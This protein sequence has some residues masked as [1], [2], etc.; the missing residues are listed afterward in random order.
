MSDGTYQESISVTTADLTLRS[1][2][3]RDST[4]IENAGDVVSPE[5]AQCGFLIRGPAT[6]FTL[7]GAADQGFT[8][9]GGTSTRLIQLNNGPSGVEISYNKI[10]TTG[11]ATTG[12][13]IGAAGA[14]GLTVSNNIF[15][16]DEATYQD[17]PL[18][19]PDTTN[20]VLDVTVTG[21][22]FTGS[23]TPDK[24][25]AAICLGKIGVSSLPESTIAG[26]TI[27][28]FD[29]GIIISAD[30]AD[31]DVSGN[32]IS[33]CDK[34]VQ[35]RTGTHA[36]MENNTFANNTYNIYHAAE[37]L[38]GGSSFY[39]NIQDAIDAASSGD[40]I[41]VY[42]GTYT[43]DLV[44]NIADLTL[45][46]ETGKANTTIQ[47]VDG[48]GIDIQGGA[49]NFTLG[50]AVDQGFTVLSGTTTTFLIQLTNAPSDVEI[51]YNEI[52]T[53]GNASQ[54]ISVGAAGATFDHYLE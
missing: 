24:Y 3:G 19:G 21:N 34:G 8:F 6:N 2:N 38:T 33:D 37:I 36:E 49:S 28:A 47:L 4:I 39:G 44:V 27:S 43:E 17:W 54:G 35:F 53:T 26:N 7:G 45:Q 52:D 30:S 14:T 42:A 31:L 50:G 16:A 29:R 32:T 40:A 23:G 15:I 20:P 46:S 5:V 10:D 13:N 41:L 11:D 25:G 9:S 22:E 48:V 1:E 18:I 51:S 12:I